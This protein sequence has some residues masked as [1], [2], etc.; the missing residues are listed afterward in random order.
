MSF[1]FQKKWAGNGSFDHHV[2][3]QK[4][5]PAVTDAKGSFEMVGPELEEQVCLLHLMNDVGHS[6]IHAE[7]AHIEIQRIF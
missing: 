2:S 6:A 5:E 3:I 1:P 7:S 4:I